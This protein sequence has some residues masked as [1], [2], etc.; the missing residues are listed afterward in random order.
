MLPGQ[1][2]T[3]ILKTKKSVVRLCEDNVTGSYSIGINTPDGVQ[4][5]YASKELHDLMV[6]ELSQQDGNS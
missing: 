2:S 3:E 1:K 6:K 5:K 4:W